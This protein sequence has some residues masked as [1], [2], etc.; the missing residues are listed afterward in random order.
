MIGCQ[1]LC[2][3]RGPIQVLCEDQDVHSIEQLRNVLAET[4]YGSRVIDYLLRWFESWSSQGVL[5]HGDLT[6][7]ELEWL[8]WDLEPCSNETHLMR[9]CLKKHLWQLI[10]WCIQAQPCMMDKV[11]WHQLCDIFVLQGN[12]SALK[13]IRDKD[14][15][16]ISE[17][18][19]NHA[20]FCGHLPVVEFLYENA[21]CNE[22]NVFQGF[23]TACEQ[24]HLHVVQWLYSKLEPVPDTHQYDDIVYS[25]LYSGCNKNQL[26]VV[27]W[28]CDTKL[29]TGSLIDLELVK[30]LLVETSMNTETLTWLLS[31]CEPLSDE[32]NQLNE[33]LE[34]VCSDDNLNLAQWL[35]QRLN[36]QFCFDVKKMFLRKCLQNQLNMARWLWEMVGPTKLDSDFLQDVFC[37]ALNCRD[38]EVSTLQW[39]YTLVPITQEN[40]IQGFVTQ[41]HNLFAKKTVLRWVVSLKRIPLHIMEKEYEAKKKYRCFYM[42]MISDKNLQNPRLRPTP[43]SVAGSNKTS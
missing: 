35:A 27:C 15:L 18:D 34:I 17:D 11:K 31:K 6:E 38:I 9:I 8:G 1:E 33:L 14:R 30:Y 36:Y 3:F 39:L 41:T 42:N 16:M 19:F 4:P 10:E 21:L 23:T 26:H 29:P 13:W 25:G 5:Y 24:G 22:M 12:V 28:I 20:C 40:L 43:E 2:L 37:K 7:N 32:T